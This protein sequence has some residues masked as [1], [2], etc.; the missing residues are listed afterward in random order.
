[1]CPENPSLPL[2]LRLWSFLFN[3]DV[4]GDLHIIHIFTK[5]KIIWQRNWLERPYLDKMNSNKKQNMCNGVFELHSKSFL[6]VQNP[7]RASLNGCDGSSKLVASVYV[8]GENLFGE[9]RR[10]FRLRK[11]TWTSSWPR[12]KEI[13]RSLDTAR[14]FYIE[15]SMVLIDR[16]EWP[17][18]E[19]WF[20]GI[21]TVLFFL[22][23]LW[24][25]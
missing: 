12:Y 15:S 6:R 1:M 8:V 9:Q 3:S 25:K 5:R 16:V 2:S 11:H 13:I 17:E 14:S 7:P 19:D 10:Y 21:N 23:F 4:F 18:I 20:Q 22:L 24:H